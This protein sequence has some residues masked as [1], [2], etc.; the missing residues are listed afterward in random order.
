MPPQLTNLITQ[1]HLT[2]PDLADI[3]QALMR[4]MEPLPPE[5]WLLPVLVLFTLGVTAVVDA[6]TGK[7]SDMAIALGLLIVV[8][9]FGFYGHWQTAAQQLGIGFGA[10]IAVWLINQI[11][12]NLTK[13]DAIGMGDAK[14]TALAAAM[15]GFK[16][17]IAAWIVGAWLGI[18]FL[19]L[20]RLL[21]ARIYQ[22]HFAPFLFVGLL[23][24]FYWFYLR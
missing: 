2:I 23:G 17:V 24:G 11:Y 6:F 4:L 20:A 5:T 9:V 1:L 14:W 13:R 21:R 16:P 22:L 10:A 19:G 8:A 7:I 12:F 3:H 15:F 18:M